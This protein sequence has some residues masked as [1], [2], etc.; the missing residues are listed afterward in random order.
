MPEAK[1]VVDILFTVL[2]TDWKKNNAFVFII[3]D[4]TAYGPSILKMWKISLYQAWLSD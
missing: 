4:V 2:G 3:L 1:T